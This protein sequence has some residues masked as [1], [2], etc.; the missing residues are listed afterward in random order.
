MRRGRNGIPQNGQN[1]D[2]ILSG[3]RDEASGAEAPGQGRN[4]RQDR[5]WS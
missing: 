2:R 3:K 4:L 1:R 5:I